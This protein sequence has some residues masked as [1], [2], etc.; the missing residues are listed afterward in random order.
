MIDSE[1]INN[2][3]L[4]QVIEMLK[5]TSQ[6]ASK[7]MQIYIV[8]EESEWIT[9]QVHIEVMILKDSQKL[10]FDVLN[11]IKYNVILKM[12]WLHKKNS[13]IN[14]I[15]KELYIMI[16]AYKI[17]EQSEMSLSEYKSWD[18]EILLLNNKQSKWMS[19]YSMS[20]DQLKKVRTYLNEN[21]KRGFI[22]SSKSLTEYLILFVSKKN[23]TKQLC[24]NYKQLNEI[25]RWDSYFLLL[26]KEL[27]N[28]LNRVKWF[29]SLNLKEAYYQVQMKKG[30]EWKMTFWTRYKHYKYTIMLF[31]LKN[32]LII[33]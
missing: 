30:K 16:D 26:I 28:Q 9:D 15:S 29:T 18:H 33:F 24:V 1:A 13:R 3:I 14:W 23:D 19:L 6:W 17:S 31:E 8:N 21:L 20:E 7:P 10:T 5:L 4:Q 32:T 25:T 11:S 2:Y 27:Q 22:R 12:L